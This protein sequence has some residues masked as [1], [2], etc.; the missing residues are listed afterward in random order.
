M[1]EGQAQGAIAPA[2]LAFGHGA[3]APPSH[4]VCK[5]ISEGK[6]SFNDIVALQQDELSNLLVPF[7]DVS[8]LQEHPDFLSAQALPDD[9]DDGQVKASSIKALTIRAIVTRC[10]NRGVDV[11]GLPAQFAG[12]HI[13]PITSLSFDELSTL[14]VDGTADLLAS[15]VFIGAH[16]TLCFILSPLERSNLCNISSAVMGDDDKVEYFSEI[17]EILKRRGLY[18]ERAEAQ[19]ATAVQE[20][21]IGQ[22]LLAGDVRNS[23]FEVQPVCPARS[24][25]V[26][27]AA[28]A[29]AASKRMASMPHV[30]YLPGMPPPALM[31]QVLSDPNQSALSKAQSFMV[32]NV[33]EQVADMQSRLM[34]KE[35]EDWAVEQ[36]PT[37]MDSDFG[38]K[39]F[40]KVYEANA[41]APGM[42][43]HVWRRHACSGPRYTGWDS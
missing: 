7:L 24:A 19:L 11:Q 5:A 32:D 6:V 14:G 34:L 25:A 37:A 41:Q 40:K 4:P 17:I 18:D 9:D 31:H 1:S 39:A 20:P 3:S 13:D 12:L 29:Y 10:F 42:R 16:D 21:P 26:N 33:T 43:F 30:P 36:Y 2:P 22:E 38:T 23:L 35:C 8:R 28:R 27:T 15:A